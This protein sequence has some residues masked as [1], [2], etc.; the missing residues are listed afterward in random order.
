MFQVRRQ[1]LGAAE[2]QA[3]VGRGG[4][5]DNFERDGAAAAGR[6]GPLDG[7]QIRSR[8]EGYGAGSRSARAEG[9]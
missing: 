6:D 4:P 1:C 9:P 5:P 8:S 2:R 7:F 3:R